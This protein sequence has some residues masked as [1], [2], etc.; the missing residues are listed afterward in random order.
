[1][2]VTLKLDNDDAKVVKSVLE[3][4][5]DL[6][7]AVLKGGETVTFLRKLDALFNSQVKVDKLRDISGAFNVAVRANTTK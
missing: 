1:M 4:V 3:I 6:Q 5:T 2:S 7:A